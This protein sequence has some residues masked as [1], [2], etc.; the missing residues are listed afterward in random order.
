MLSNTFLHAKVTFEVFS[1]PSGPSHFLINNKPSGIFVACL[2]YKSFHFQSAFSPPLGSTTLHP[3][4][5]NPPET[6]LASKRSLPGVPLI[7][8]S[9]KFLLVENYTD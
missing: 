2:P 5:Q 4:R 9:E 1:V 6:G 8:N 7:P 3:R